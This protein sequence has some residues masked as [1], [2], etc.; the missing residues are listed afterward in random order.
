MSA[1]STLPEALLLARFVLVRRDGAQPPLSPV[2]DGPN[3]VLERSTHFF[4]LEM[5]ERTDKV[6]TLCLKAARTP[7][8][9]EPAK[10]PRRGRPVAQASATCPR[11]AADTA[12]VAATFDLQPSTYSTTNNTIHISIRPPA[13]Q[14]PATEP[15]QPLSL[16]PQSLGGTCGGVLSVPATFPALTA[17]DLLYLTHAVYMYII[18]LACLS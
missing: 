10:P 12:G 9:T 5:G 6:S 18:A 1:P 7:A 15:T 13:S 8:D 3:R 16:P 11:A 17:C 2:Y 4:L 14:H